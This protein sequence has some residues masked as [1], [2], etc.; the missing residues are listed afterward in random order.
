MTQQRCDEEFRIGGWVYT[1]IYERTWCPNWRWKDNEP[2]GHW[3]EYRG[4]WTW[5]GAGETVN[6]N[7]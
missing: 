6:G 4:E 1:R 5:L 3:L 7:T 2:K